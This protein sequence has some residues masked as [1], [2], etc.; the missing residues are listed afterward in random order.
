MTL[1]ETLKINQLPKPG[2]SATPEAQVMAAKPKR[3]K[4]TLTQLESFLLR[5]AD[6][7][8][9]TGMDASEYKEY[10]FGML[11]LKRL[12]D[13]FEE[14]LET[15]QRKASAEGKS[16]KQ[17]QALLRNKK[18]F[19]FWI[20]ERARWELA[21]PV[22]LENAQQFRGL[23][24]VK[25]LVGD[26]VNKALA[27]I[28]E[29]NVEALSG[30]L[31]P[32]NFMA[33]KGDK[34]RRVDDDVIVELI[35][36]F[37]TV[38][39]ANGWFEFPDLLGAGYEYLIKYFADT[40]GKKGGEF[41]TPAPVVRL[42]VQLME[43]LE[44]MSVGDPTCGSGG[45]LVQTGSYVEES[46][47]DPSTLQLCGQEVNP[48]TWA[49]CKMNM[50]LHGYKAADIRNDD[51]LKNPR[52]LAE[53]GELMLMDRQI[54][55]PPFSLNYSAKEMQFKE[56]F[57]TFMPETGK[58]A[59]LMF[60]Q[61]ILATLAAEGKAA[62]VMP[63]GVL[64]RGSKEKEAR[65]RMVLAGQL[66]A[67][68]GLPPALFYGTGIP[69]C[70]L[71]LNKKSASKRKHVLFVNADRE[72]EEGK[73]QNSLRPEDIEKISYVYHEMLEVPAYS[74]R[75]PIKELE[76]EDFNLNIRRY[77]DN[78]PPPEPQ[79][80]RA[81][82]HGGVPTLEVDALNHW[83]QNYVGLREVLF[84]T[85]KADLTY[86][87]FTPALKADKSAAK[88]LVESHEAVRAKHADFH[89]VLAKW[90]A[91]NVKDL[92]ALPTT[93][94]YFPLKKKF[95][96][97]LEDLLLPFGLLDQFQIRGAFA[98]FSSQLAA[99][100]KSVAASGW[101][102]EL[103][104]ADE[105]LRSQFPEVLAELEAAQSRIAELQAMFDAVKTEE[106]EE[107]EEVDLSTYDFDDEQPVLPK[108]VVDALKAR[109]K[110]V[111]AEL[112]T[113]KKSGNAAYHAELTAELEQ[114][115]ELL[116]KHSALEEELKTAK[117]TVKSIEKRRDEL[118]ERARDRITSEEAERLI[119]NRWMVA[120][121]E[122]YELRLQKYRLC[123]V[124]LIG[125]LWD[126]YAVTLRD[127]QSKRESAALHLA[128]L[129]RERGIE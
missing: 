30:V 50:I 66:E 7:L 73:S 42:L 37:S 51:T 20:P 109:K 69:A 62:V 91:A 126:K 120:L 70:V 67:V 57:H 84:G 43:P 17:V 23:M 82:L 116:G 45:M 5:A 19:A 123:L 48:T 39:L 31:K 59:D 54:A 29:D 63:H 33:T 64:F 1:P 58:K 104:P 90:W 21:E 95:A 72:Y 40:A 25:K 103:I 85:R 112:K 13:Q 114:A 122:A 9:K 117:Q 68:I 119:L 129:L 127:I 27:A 35:E 3:K 111:A 97:S 98:E 15:L 22:T 41:Y 128:C 61:H 28:E 108:A 53:N 18:G 77:V 105:I 12:S 87:D 88:T 14:D 26:M 71:V 100:F 75:V 79:D 38:H 118:V 93:G 115:D 8:R 24:H 44:L 2:L 106:G 110:E 32:I 113:V 124:G 76:A 4:L 92:R 99:D 102:A 47:G 46:G 16:E 36:H 60:V 83:W 96:Q 80:V 89:G 94:S 52:H 121:A 101:N 56:R 81:H 6:I 125:R 11:F 34:K 49:I 78:S 10:L 86:V 74:R 107:E 65:K 55:N